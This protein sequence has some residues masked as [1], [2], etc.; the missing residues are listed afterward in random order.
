MFPFKIVSQDDF[1]VVSLAEAKAQCR[2]MTSF[3]MDDSFIEDVLM[4]AACSIAQTHVNFLLSPGVV[5]QYFD[6]S[7]TYQLYGGG[8]ISI[9]TVI[10]D[11]VEID[12]WSY[13]SITEEITINN[14]YE[15][16]YVTY[17][18]GS[19]SVD[20]NIRIAILMLI[21]TMYN[22]REDYI[23]GLSVEQMPMTSIKL[24]DMSKVYVS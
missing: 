21:S 19:S 7:G 15:E 6:V 4:P 11:G 16:V 23:T 9:T 13:N 3:T 10:A 5:E 22:N 14:A 8:D 20:A 12:D 18:C 17:D 1:S 24:L 2:L